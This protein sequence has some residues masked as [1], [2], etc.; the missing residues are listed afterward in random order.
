MSVGVALGA[1]G[2]IEAARA[3]VTTAL[4]RAPYTA[5]DHSAYTSCSPGRPM[6]TCAA[7]SAADARRGAL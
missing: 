3:D 6:P 2:V 4:V 7:S 1:V 5:A